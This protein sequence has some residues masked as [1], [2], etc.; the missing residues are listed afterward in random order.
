MTDI[1][2]LDVATTYSYSDQQP[3]LEEDVV[4]RRCAR[5]VPERRVASWRERERDRSGKGIHSHHSTTST[6]G[7]LQS[8]STIERR[9]TKA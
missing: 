2:V 3:M 4:R 6:G 5:V 1:I 7:S 8:S 9:E